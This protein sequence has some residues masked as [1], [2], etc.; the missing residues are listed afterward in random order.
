MNL[1]STIKE[2][3]N[4][5]SG[6]ILID[7]M[8]LEQNSESFWNLDSETSDRL[9]IYLDNGILKSIDIHVAVQLLRITSELNIDLLLAFALTIRAQRNGHV[10]FDMSEMPNFEVES[11]E[12]ANPQLFSEDEI[13]DSKNLENTEEKNMEIFDETNSIDNS[14]SKEAEIFGSQ[15]TESEKNHETKEPEM[16]EKLDSEEDF[17][18]PAFLRKQKN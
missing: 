11:I 12:L 6:Q 1:I 2:I 5:I 15:D 18:I 3:K 10:A 13:I 14:E 9:Q 4:K 16:F 17:E 8:N 7:G